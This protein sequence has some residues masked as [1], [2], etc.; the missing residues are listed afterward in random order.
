MCRRRPLG[1]GGLRSSSSVAEARTP[2]WRRWLLAE[3]WR[4]SLGRT[5]A[6]ITGCRA[7]LSLEFQHCRLITGVNAKMSVPS[8]ILRETD[9]VLQR[10]ILR[11]LRLQGLQ[12]REL[13]RV[14][15]ELH[16]FRHRVNTEGLEVQLLPVVLVEVET[17]M[18]LFEGRSFRIVQIMT[19]GMT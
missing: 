14:L 17:Q 16:E 6:E 12:C 7:R 9:E 3:C 13:H 5:L 10:R 1:H 2:C 15:H 4:R 18:S 11:Q 19:E 8:G